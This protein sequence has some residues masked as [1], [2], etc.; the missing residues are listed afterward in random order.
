[1]GSNKKDQSSYGI[2][3]LVGLRELRRCHSRREDDVRFQSL[4]GGHLGPVRTVRVLEITTTVTVFLTSITFEWFNR[5][6]FSKMCTSLQT[7]SLAA[8]FQASLNN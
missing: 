4:V 7:G 3:G 1:M 6:T 5:I 2:K 8:S